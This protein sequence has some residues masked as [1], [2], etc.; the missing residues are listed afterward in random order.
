MNDTSF[1]TETVSFYEKLRLFLLKT[2]TFLPKTFNDC[3]FET[4]T[5][6]LKI[7]NA[8]FSFDNCKN[9]IKV[10]NLKK[11]TLLIFEI[12]EEIFFVRLEIFPFRNF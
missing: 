12:R 4:L 6:K 11:L 5:T 1:K 10:I 9:Q 8:S 7:G 2:E 3:A